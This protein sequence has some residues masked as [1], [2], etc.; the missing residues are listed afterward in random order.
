MQILIEVA[1][2]EQETKY[3]QSIIQQSQAYRKPRYHIP[4]Y[5]EGR[6][7]KV[8][9]HIMLNMEWTK[10]IP[11]SHITELNPGVYDIESN[12]GKSWRAVIPSGTCTCPS[13]VSTNIPCK[14]FFAVFYHHTKWNWKDL[15]SSLT[16]A[17]HMVLDNI[18]EP[19][20]ST[21]I[22]WDMP[23]KSDTST[24]Y[25]QE[26]PEPKPTTATQI[27]K[28]QKQIEDSV[29]RC[30]TLAYLTSDITVLESA[31]PGCL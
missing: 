29:A 28:V 16:E 12:D 10:A 24:C 14:H 23:N 13:F 11:K 9:S 21:S 8:Q 22:N 27:Y 26:L 7:Q 17:S 5:L 4:S 20:T 15:P 1:F 25:G 18:N 30:C 3:N 19:T 6:P 31:L 2:K